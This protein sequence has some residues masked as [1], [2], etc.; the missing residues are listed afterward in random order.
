MIKK[1]IK[2]TDFDGNSQVE[3]AYFNLTKPE[4][5]RISMRYG[6][7]G[8]LK[9]GI[10]ELIAHDDGEKLVSFLE[11]VILTSYGKRVEGGKKFL[12]TRDSRDDFEYS[13]AYAELFGELLT[14]TQAM[15]QFTSTLFADTS[16]QNGS[17]NQVVAD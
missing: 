8:D 15:E 7:N 12:K 6:V 11:D 9:E 1:E 16:A 3:Q 17:S 2:Y 10:A 5:T 4:V 13:A 14:D